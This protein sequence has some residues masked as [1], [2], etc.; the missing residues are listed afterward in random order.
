MEARHVAVPKPPPHSQKTRLGGRWRVVT[1]SKTANTLSGTLGT[2]R[3]AWWSSLSA[4]KRSQ[5][6]LQ[7]AMSRATL[8]E[9]RASGPSIAIA[10]IAIDSPVQKDARH[11]LPWLTGCRCDLV[12]EMQQRFQVWGEI[13]GTAIAASGPWRSAAGACA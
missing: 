7:V 12:E 4:K 2:N 10:S 1:S 3:G 8:S 5:P 6:R 9:T 13:T 11:I